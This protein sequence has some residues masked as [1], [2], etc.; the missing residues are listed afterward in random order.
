MRH[1]PLER[2][3]ARSLEKNRA[4]RSAAVASAAV[5]AARAFEPIESR[6]LLSGAGL[7]AEYFNN[8]DFTG[9][10]VRR[11][12]P[13]INFEWQERSPA[14]GI[15]P[16]TYSVR[17]TGQ[18]EPRFS[19][20]YTFSTLSDDGVR[21]W[22]NGQKIIDNWTK[23]PTTV[24]WGYIALEAGNKY[25]MRMEYFQNYG[26]AV[27]KLRWSSH[28][29]RKEAVPTS[30][31]YAPAIAPLGT[32]SG[33][34]ATYF[35]NSDFTGASA[36]R[37][38][39]TIDFD[40]ASNSPV[41]EIDPY[42]YSVRWTGQIQ[43]RYSET[44]TFYT[45][46]NDGVRLW[47]NGQQLI[48]DWN[49]H[50]ATNN[51]GQIALEAG[52]RY[53]VRLDYYQNYGTALAKLEWGSPSEPRQVV[54]TSQL[55]PSAEDPPPNPDSDP[56]A[57][58]P[59]PEGNWRMTFR[60][61][62]SGT[63][64]NPVWHTAQWWDRQYTIVEGEE[65]VYDAT[66]VSVSDGMLHLTERRETKYGMP[67]VSGLVMTG[68]AQDVPTLP[69]FNFLYGYL[70]VRAKLPAGQ[71]L[72][73]AIWMMPASYNDANGE[74]DVLEV[75]GNDPSRAYFTVHRHGSQDG[76]EW[77]GPDFSQDFHTFAVDWQPDHVAW[78]VDGI[79]RARTTDPSLICPEA[80]YPILNLAIGGD[81]GGASNATT[82]VRAAMD[83]DY[84]RV[85][86]KG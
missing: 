77:A 28:S 83:V 20:T 51:S 18:V 38:D 27:A 11:V 58:P 44:Y 67:F 73:P 71:G 81:W 30:Q 76:H 21:L 32:G 6:L 59:A 48:D 7:Q 74:L 66:G 2:T 47:V 14:E 45:T 84:I 86:Q 17:W 65:Q 34:S 5:E 16:Y 15:D 50:P 36:Q 22:V 63:S 42:T 78:Y 12:D 54:P 25:D 85:W 80:M 9:T 64:L 49:N 13:T 1:R 39:R 33:L 24:N 72:W 53:D 26:G 68:G 56:E 57:T 60:D 40:W 82:P 41:V 61:E 69:K 37:L 19:E 3:P 62:F 29:Q 35:D 75:L 31:L 46:S 55:Y 23:H 4:V 10:S 43:P 70:E 8:P 79:E 52:K